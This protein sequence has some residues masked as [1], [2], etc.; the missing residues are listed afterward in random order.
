MSCHVMHHVHRCRGMS[1][2]VK[3]TLMILN[4]LLH[5]NTSTIGHTLVL[6]DDHE[7]NLTAAQPWI[8]EVPSDWDIIRFDC[9]RQVPHFIKY[10]T[11]YV[12]TYIDIYPHA[13]SSTHVHDDS[14]HMHSLHIHT[15]INQ[16]TWLTVHDSCFPPLTP[17]AYTP[18]AAYTPH[19]DL[20]DRDPRGHC[21]QQHI[22]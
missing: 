3:S 2:L 13:L 21:V 10:I 12:S 8:S 7:V 15:R 18:H 5:S 16:C 19:V 20:Q 22:R 11:P 9:K 6:E 14:T 1:G 17:H 4:T